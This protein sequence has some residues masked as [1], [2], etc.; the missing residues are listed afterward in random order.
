MRSTCS[1][2]DRRSDVPPW[3]RSLHTYARRNRDELLVAALVLLIAGLFGLLAY[4]LS[5]TD[6]E[7]AEADH[8]KAWAVVNTLEEESVQA[9][10]DA[11]HHSKRASESRQAAEEDKDSTDTALVEWFESSA[12][13]H[14]QLSKANWERR[15]NT[16]HL[17]AEYRRLLAEAE[18]EILRAK[19]AR[20]RGTP[21]K[22]SP[23]VREILAPVLGT[24]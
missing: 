2:N 14:K 13:G 16:L 8:E 4:T 10:K 11:R 6:I 19:D 15:E 20:D 17:A 1:C 7:K 23:R 3:L 12:H 18:C 5:P 21:Y 22:V 9:G 24:H